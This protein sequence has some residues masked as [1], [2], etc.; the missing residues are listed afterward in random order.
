MC[1]SINQ[2]VNT[3]DTKLCKSFNTIDKTN[4]EVSILNQQKT[5]CII[6]NNIFCHL[7]IDD[8]YCKR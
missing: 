2:M 5:Q 1:Q 4:N 7:Y 3:E 6:K 8:K